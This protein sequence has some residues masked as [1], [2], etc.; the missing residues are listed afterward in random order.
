M[1]TT[2]SR[3]TC[4]ELPHQDLH[5]STFCT[6]HPIRLR[7]P[8]CA[9]HV[10]HQIRC[11]MCMYTQRERCMMMYVCMC[12]SFKG[13]WV[14]EAQGFDIRQRKMPF[15][16]W[17]QPGGG[18]LSGNQAGRSLLAGLPL[19]GTCGGSANVPKALGD[20]RNFFSIGRI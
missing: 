4:Q 8:Q 12:L 3:G 18:Q 5:R 6:V 13:L 7:Y 9:V 15:P 20:R 11:S 1:I 17:T 10:Y 19:R 16:N 2:P 14:L